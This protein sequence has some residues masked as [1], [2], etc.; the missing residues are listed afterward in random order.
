MKKYLKSDLKILS[1]MVLCIALYFLSDDGNWQCLTEVQRVSADVRPGNVTAVLRN[2]VYVV[3]GKGK[4]T[5]KQIPNK[6]LKRKIKKIVI[7]KGVTQIPEKAFKDCRNAKIIKIASS[8]RNIG[9]QAFYNTAIKSIILPKSVKKIGW[10]ICQECR[11]LNEMTLPGNLSIFNNEEFMPKMVSSC[12]IKKDGLKTVKRVKFSTP[13][14]PWN[15]IYVGDCE[16]F[17]VS[18]SDPNYKSIDGMIYT[19]DGRMLVAIPYARKKVVVAEG[20]ETVDTMSYSYT[21]REAIDKFNEEEIYNGCGEIEKIIFPSSLKKVTDVMAKKY[22]N[23]IYTGKNCRKNTN[24]QVKIKSKDLAVKSMKLLWKSN[25][26]WRKSLAK[27]FERLGS[28][29]I[30]DGMVVLSDGYL[31]G[32]IGDKSDAKLQLPNNVKIIGENAFNTSK[33]VTN[34]KFSVKSIVLCDGLEKIEDYAFDYDGLEVYCGNQ[35][36]SISEKAFWNCENYE[37]IRQKS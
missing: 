17:E 24:I 16:N 32:Y 12:F 30:T 23:T 28:A 5:K 20:C 4:M 15:V 25:I 18:K 29:K 27:E 10:A 35:S 31:V 6:K 37:I 33:E 13:I 3:S 7:K 34:E 8:V 11:N 26:L 14:S 9:T 21:A 36:L 1:V 19:K 22:W 2:G